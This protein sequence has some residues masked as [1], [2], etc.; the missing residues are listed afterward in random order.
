MSHG[1]KKILSSVLHK[2]KGNSFLLSLSYCVFSSLP[3]H[4]KLLIW[5]EILGGRKKEHNYLKLVEDLA[6]I[7]FFLKTKLSG[8]ATHCATSVL[9]TAEIAGQVKPWGPERPNRKTYKYTA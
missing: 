3:V 6:G 9:A 7:S 4:L 1:K 8:R 5:P 2:Y